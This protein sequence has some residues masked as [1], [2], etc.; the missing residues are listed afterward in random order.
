[1]K[2][3]NKSFFWSFIVAVIFLITFACL[4]SCVATKKQREKFLRENCTIASVKEFKDS[5]SLKE[6]VKHDSIY[7]SVEGPIKYLPSPCEK[8]CD[9]LGNLKPF[10]QENKKNGIK[11]SLYSVGNVLVQECD[12]DSLLKVNKTLTKEIDRYHN[13]KTEIQ[14]HDNCKLAHLTDKDIFWRIV[15][16]R[17]SIIVL[18]YI[19]LRILKIYLKKVPWLAWLAKIII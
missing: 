4:S 5:I 7:V 11:Q 9:S 15:G 8:L 18:I 17:L 16:I 19:A 13:E 6:T 10:N 14:I 1:M 2:N 12:V 3:T